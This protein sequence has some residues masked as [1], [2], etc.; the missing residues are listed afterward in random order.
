MLPELTSSWT[1][2]AA[3]SASLSGETIPTKSPAGPWKAS[4]SRGPGQG[5][6]CGR[7][8]STAGSRS[9]KPNHSPT[10]PPA[11]PARLAGGPAQRVPPGALAPPVP[12]LPGPRGLAGSHAGFVV[13]GRHGDRLD[14]PLRLFGGPA[15]AGQRPV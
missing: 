4:G 9:S 8:V 2:R 7:G 5:W 13:S 3:G 12:F 10:P 14:E 6:G 15:G 11:L 1:S